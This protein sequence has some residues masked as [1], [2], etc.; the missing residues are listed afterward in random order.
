MSAHA[1]ALYR[2]APSL[3]GTQTLLEPAKLVSFPTKSLPV[4]S[5]LFFFGSRRLIVS[6]C[7]RRQ[8]RSESNCDEL[9][10][11]KYFIDATNSSPT[12]TPSRITSFTTDTLALNFLNSS[13]FVHALNLIANSLKRD[14]SNVFFEA[15]RIYSF[16]FSFHFLI[17]LSR[18]VNCPEFR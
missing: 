15:I 10:S 14:S 4:F 5:G 11:S 9:Y 16:N 18:T 8:I 7:S 2:Y 1:S 13:W 3:F 6:H 17:G 12:I